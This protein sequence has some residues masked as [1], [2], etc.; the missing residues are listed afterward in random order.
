[1]RRKPQKRGR[2]RLRAAIFSV[3]AKLAPHSKMRVFFHRLRGVNI[4]EDVEI[5][6]LVI[7]DNVY[8]ELVTIEKEVTIAAR[9]TVLAHDESAL[10]TGIGEEVIKSTRICE[11]AFIGVHSVILA[12]VTVG[13]RAIVGAGSVVAADVADGATVAGVPAK[14]IS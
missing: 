6:Y 11:G 3:P 5:G 4:G 12:G 2:Q 9:S 1:M 14:P 13:R 7:I 10:Y 8:P